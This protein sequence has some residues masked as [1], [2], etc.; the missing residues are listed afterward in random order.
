MDDELQEGQIGME[1]AVQ[2]LGAERQESRR[3]RQELDAAQESNR[4]LD[5]A[6]LRLA[7]Q[8]DAAMR[9]LEEARAALRSVVSLAA[10]QLP[11]GAA[12]AGQLH[13]R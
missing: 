1:V 9:D 5:E 10:S 6:L 7:E 3:L 13:A 12:I 11:N 8:R 2:L 4:R